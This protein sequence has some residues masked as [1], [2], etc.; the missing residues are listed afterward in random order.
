MHT[1]FSDNVGGTGPAAS[2]PVSERPKRGRSAVLLDVE[3]I[4]RVRD[5]WADPQE[6]EH[7]MRLID[8]YLLG[9]DHI[10]AAGARHTLSRYLPSIVAR[11]IAFTL[12]QATPNAA[13]AALLDRAELLKS[14]GYSQVTVVSGDHAFAPLAEDFELIIVAFPGKLSRSLELA[15]HRVISLGMTKPRPALVRHPAHRRAQPARPPGRPRRRHRRTTTTGT[16][17]RPGQ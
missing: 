15:A 1:K 13:D 7:R 17:R 11:G 12:V 9:A 10:V 6:F 3:N 5:G 2:K 8:P 4:A 14:C 16:A